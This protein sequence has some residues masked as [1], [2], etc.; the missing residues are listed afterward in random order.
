MIEPLKELKIEDGFI[1]DMKE[2]CDVLMINKMNSKSDDL[3]NKFWL[4]FS[5]NL[6][7]GLAYYQLKYGC[8]NTVGFSWEGSIIV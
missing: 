6:A 2:L 1:K 7:K 3:R 8:Y 4:R 5:Y